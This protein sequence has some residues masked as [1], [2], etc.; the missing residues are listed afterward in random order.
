MY[1]K[2]ATGLSIA[3]RIAGQVEASGLHVGEFA[4]R[5]GLDEAKLTSSLT[6]GRRVT[7]LDVARIAEFCGISV[8]WLLTGKRLRWWTRVWESTVIRATWRL[9]LLRAWP[10]R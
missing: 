10:R 3:E 6:G 8:W 5:A 4:R 9:G 2:R 7:S 1:P